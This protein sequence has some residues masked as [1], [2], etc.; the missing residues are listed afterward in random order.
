MTRING[1]INHF[2]HCILECLRRVKVK[3]VNYSQ[4]TAVEQGTLEIPVA[5][6]QRL[7]D[8]LQKHTNIALES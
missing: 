8:V 6:L 2:I 1:P 3:P 5:F 7:M 4:V